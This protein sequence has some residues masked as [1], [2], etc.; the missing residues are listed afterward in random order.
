[1]TRAISLSI[2]ALLLV[3][4]LALADPAV[5]VRY[6]DGVPQ[7]HLEGS[8][9]QARYTVYRATAT[10]GPWAAFTEFNTL[11]V[12]P[13]YGE[14]AE[15]EP[16]K[17]YWYRFELVLQD[18]SLVTY[19]PYQVTISPVLA[20]RVGARVVPNPSRAASRIE[21][22]LAGP[23][24]AGPTRATAVLYDLQGRAIRTVFSGMLE[25]GLTR[26]D[27]DGRAEGGRAIA[28]GQYYLR[29]TT[30]LGVSTTRVLRVN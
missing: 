19:G 5:D 17:S 18:G 1:M 8:Y 14:D 20:R 13:C 9:P 23:A 25:R 27:W 3:A 29:L 16:G 7:I 6:F 4:G 24:N 12:G 2:A 30:P 21:L 11:C 28:A 22:F 10:A 15:A 26:L